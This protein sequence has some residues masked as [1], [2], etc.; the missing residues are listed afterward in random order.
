MDEESFP[1]KSDFDGASETRNRQREPFLPRSPLATSCATV[2]GTGC[3]NFIPDTGGHRLLRMSHMQSWY[4][5]EKPFQ[6]VLDSKER[7]FAYTQ[8]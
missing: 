8:S 3:I 2:S 7:R 1:T 6:T 4:G 5:D